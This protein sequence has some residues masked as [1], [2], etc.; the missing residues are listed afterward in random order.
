MN[1]AAIGSV[2]ASLVSSVVDYWTA[3]AERKEEIKAK[4]IADINALFD[5]IDTHLLDGNKTIDAEADAKFGKQLDAL[6]AD[7]TKPVTE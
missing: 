1:W 3:S 6:V 4:A 2:L 7:A 5:L